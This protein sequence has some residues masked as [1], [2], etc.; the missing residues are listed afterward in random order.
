MQIW[1]S[2]KLNSSESFFCGIHALNGSAYIVPCLVT[3]SLIIVFFYGPPIKGTATEMHKYLVNV[4]V[5]VYSKFCRL[6]VNCQ[7][8]KLVNKR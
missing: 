8:I 6:V 1:F 7:A 2:E 4:R 3:A 5:L